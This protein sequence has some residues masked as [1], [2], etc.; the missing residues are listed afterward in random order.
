MG[1]AFAAAP[2]LTAL[3]IGST[4]VSAGTAIFS[5]IQQSKALKEQ[6]KA[7]SLREK[8]SAIAGL[9]QGNEILRDQLAA[10]AQ[11]N[12]SAGAS[13]IDPFSGTPENTVQAIRDVA[14]RQLRTSRLNTQFDL[15]ASASRRKQLSIQA[16]TARTRGF[17]GAGSSLLDLSTSLTKLGGTEAPASG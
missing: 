15:A 11:V 4:V 6:R 1:A 2:I 3:A 10:T 7:E 12:V 8:Q 14:E 9:Q 16:S 13:G 5:G 17:L